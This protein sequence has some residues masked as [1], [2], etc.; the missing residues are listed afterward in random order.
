MRL[1]P[2]F[3][4][5]E[6]G[7]PQPSTPTAPEPSEDLR[8]L[9]RLRAASA[10]LQQDLVHLKAG[11]LDALADDGAAHKLIAQ[12]LQSFFSPLLDAALEKKYSTKGEFSSQAI[13]RLGQ[14]FHLGIFGSA[15]AS[16]AGRVAS[17]AVGGAAHA[18]SAQLAGVTAA[19]GLMAFIGASSQYVAIS[20]KN[21][22]RANVET[23]SMRQQ[24]W[25]GATALPHESMGMR[26]S[27]AAIGKANTALESARHNSTIRAAQALLT[28][29][30][31]AMDHLPARTT[32]DVHRAQA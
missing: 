4:D 31:V 17:A 13:Q 11:N 30:R 16:T 14:A 10:A 9:Q 24:F 20:E 5:L 2:L 22:R 29:W 25:N 3:V 1:T 15:A 7:L 23:V 26:A 12:G 32:D 21:H 28:D 27:S 18:S 19:S 8:E 6:L